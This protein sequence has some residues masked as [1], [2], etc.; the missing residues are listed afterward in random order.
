MRNFLRKVKTIT[1]ILVPIFIGLI[2]GGIIADNTAAWVS[3]IILL[4]V[5]II[6]GIALQY[7]LEHPVSYDNWNSLTFDEKRAIAHDSLEKAKQEMR[8]N[9]IDIDGAIGGLCDEF[10]K[11]H[12]LGKYSNI[13]TPNDNEAYEKELCEKMNAIFL[14][15]KLNGGARLVQNI[16][17]DEAGRF[18]LIVCENMPHAPSNN[19]FNGLYVI[20]VEDLGDEPA[21]VYSF[22]SM[23]GTIG[24]LVFLFLVRT[25]NT[26]LRLFTVET[27][28]P[29]ALCEYANGS[30][31]NYGQIELADVP[32]RITEILKR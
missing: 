12:K 24:Q 31:L 5:D 13:D 1:H 30:H 26:K 19:L 28:F 9:G 23:Q 29:F 21:I 20:S 11:D 14:R 25:K 4:A 27:S 6:I 3:G 22:K 10:N 7:R 16:K 2:I 8:D 32:T 18:L 17:A 15:L